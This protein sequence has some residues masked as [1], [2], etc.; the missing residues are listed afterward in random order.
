M[1]LGIRA[2][3][4]PLKA[5][6]FCNTA[7]AFAIQDEAGGRCQPGVARRA[8]IGRRSHRLLTEGGKCPAFEKHSVA[9]CILDSWHNGCRM[10]ND[11]C[12][13]LEHLK[14]T[15][16]SKAGTSMSLQR[17]GRP[18]AAHFSGVQPGHARNGRLG[19]DGAPCNAAQLLPERVRAL[20]DGSGLGLGSATWALPLV[21]R[22]EE[23]AKHPTHSKIP[24]SRKSSACGLHDVVPQPCHDVYVTFQDVPRMLSCKAVRRTYA[25]GHIARWGLRICPPAWPQT[26]APSEHR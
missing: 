7:P 14:R 5:T 13:A 6:C 1:H 2:V 16:G 3:P 19:L 21:P 11:T 26:S 4:V 22:P 20:G 10:L 8:H 23:A 9:P 25:W 24:R 18:T 12:A 17:Q 15:Q